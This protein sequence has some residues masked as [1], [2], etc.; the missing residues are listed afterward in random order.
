V[1][2]VLVQAL[3]QI[4]LAMVAAVM[5]ELTVDRMEAQIVEVAEQVALLLLTAE[6]AVQA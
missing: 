2:G 1:A 3:L 5:A 4:M 6:Q